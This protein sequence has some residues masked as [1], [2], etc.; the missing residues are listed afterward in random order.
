MTMAV[1]MLER[2]VR[3]RRMHVDEGLRRGG[4]VLA[5]L[6]HFVH[7]SGVDSGQPGE[8]LD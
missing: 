3:H 6:L 5:R 4:P 7:P 2:V 1:S 8:L